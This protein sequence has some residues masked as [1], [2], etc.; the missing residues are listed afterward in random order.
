MTDDLWWS[1]RQEAMLVI[2]DHVS[3]YEERSI[4]AEQFARD[5]RDAMAREIRSHADG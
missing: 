1:L 3:D 2:A 4:I 5:V